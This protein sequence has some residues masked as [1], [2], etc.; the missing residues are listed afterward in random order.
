MKNKTRV[1][2]L[3]LVCM[4]LIS[5]TC[6]FASAASVQPT[7]QATVPEKMQPGSIIIYDD[8]LQPEVV[9]GGYLKSSEHAAT[10]TDFFQLRL[11]SIP[12]TAAAEQAAQIRLENEIATEQYRAVMSGEVIQAEPIRIYAGMKVVYDAVT[13]DI[14]NIYYPDPNEPSG[15]SIHNIP[16]ESGTA[17]KASVNQANGNVTWTWGSH[18]NTLTYRPSSDSFL[19][20]G[21][22][23]YFIGTYGNRNNRLQPYDCATKWPMI[24][25]KWATK[26]F[27]FGIWT[28]TRSLPTIRPMLAHCPMQ[29]STF[30]ARTTSASLQEPRMERR[31]ITQIM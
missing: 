25:L 4:F 2:S 23:T 13:G 20:T 18:N 17:S 1:V 24:I 5:A 30:G 3:L 22:A 14:N 8:E 26:M 6:S 9:Q 28:P 31:Q 29:L 11:A 21:R 7:G 16:V 19:G 27:R 12:V 10:V 15:Y